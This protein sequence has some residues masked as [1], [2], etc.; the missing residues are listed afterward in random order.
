MKFTIR[1]LVGFLLISM[2]IVFMVY[3]S[4]TIAEG[5]RTR[6][7]PEDLM[8]GT[9][10]GYETIEPTGY[11]FDDHT[12]DISAPLEE[13]SEQE[14]DLDKISRSL[15]NEVDPWVKKHPSVKPHKEKKT[16]EP[17]PV[18]PSA[19]ETERA[20]KAK[21]TH[22][23]HAKL[24]SNSTK[25]NSNSTSTN[26]TSTN[27]TSTNS[28]STKSNSNSTK[29]N[30]NSTKSNSNSTKPN[31]STNDPYRCLG[32]DGLIDPKKCPDALS[33]CEKPTKLTGNCEE[34]IIDIDGKPY[35]QCYG[36]CTDPDQ[37]IDDEMCKSIS[38][39]LPVQ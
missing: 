11:D 36:I 24:P 18:K 22:S 3:P 14:E 4:Q 17:S 39:Y 9:E 31:P 29:S 34:A 23:S 2:V 1:T 33:Y 7:E 21:Q 8:V 12:G 13:R 37:C 30:S 25:S 15:D 38:T 5:M 28:N 27:S 16:S 26:S 32:K 35:K 20:E 10:D 19:E 6:L